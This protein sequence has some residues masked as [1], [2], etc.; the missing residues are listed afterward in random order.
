MLEF[1]ESVVRDYG[2]WALLIGTFLEGET[3]L[4]IAGFL[5]FGG[6]LDLWLCILSA[7]VGSLS[8]DQTAFY[9]GRFKGKQF[10]ENR[11][12]WK[13]RVARVH[14][15]LERFQEALILSFRFF[16][17][18]RNLT[19]FLL[20]ASDISGLK[21]FILN[22]IGAAVWAV[23]F[24][25]A[26]YFFGLAVTT[27]LKDVHHVQL[28]ILLVAALVGLAIWIMRRRKRLKAAGGGSASADGPAGDAPARPGQ[29]NT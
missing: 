18:V 17:G 29:D 12:K 1:L 13:D 22:A 10:V 20:G 26:G 9:I 16:Y 14:Q 27:V 21:F 24:A 15:M 25:Y 28:V 6:Q 5:A 23:S 19:P 8:G 4:L 7:F 11:P 2:Y 3:I